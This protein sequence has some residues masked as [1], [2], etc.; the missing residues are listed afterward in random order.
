[1]SNQIV[2]VSLAELVAPVVRHILCLGTA[3]EQQLESQRNLLKK[4]STSSFLEI[5]LLQTQF[6]FILDTTDVINEWLFILVE[7][8]CYYTYVCIKG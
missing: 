3:G 5:L 7:Y 4:Q 8:I 6:L 2:H 1:M